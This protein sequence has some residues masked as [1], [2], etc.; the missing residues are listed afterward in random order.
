LAHVGT[1]VPTGSPGGWGGGVWASGKGIVG[2]GGSN[3]Y[4]QTGNGSVSAVD[5]GESFVK[6]TLGPAPS[7]GL[8][9]GGGY[10]VSNW[11]ALNNGDTDLGSSGPLLLPGDRLIGGGK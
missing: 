1:Y 2:D 3:I 5:F 6:L 9:F 7:Y 10:A 11:A 8:S 4:F